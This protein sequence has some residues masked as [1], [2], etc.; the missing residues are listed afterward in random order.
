MKAWLALNT[1]VAHLGTTFSCPDKQ[2]TVQLSD[3]SSVVPY[4][5]AVLIICIVERESFVGT[6]LS[7]HSIMLNRADLTMRRTK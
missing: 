3:R 7:C 1:Y 5:R 2:Q 4:T 6:V